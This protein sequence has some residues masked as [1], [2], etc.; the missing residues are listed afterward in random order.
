MSDLESEIKEVKLVLAT[1]EQAW[2]ASY[3]VASQ[4]RSEAIAV[5]GAQ[6]D[7]ALQDLAELQAVAYDLI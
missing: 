7:K 6:R 2:D 5:V 4:A 3:A 1:I